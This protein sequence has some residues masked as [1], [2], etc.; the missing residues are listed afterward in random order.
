MV[1]LRAGAA[2]R[3]LRHFVIRRGPD[4]TTVGIN[5]LIG[6]TER[7]LRDGPQ[8]RRARLHLALGE[9][10]KALLGDRVVIQKV[11]VNMV[12]N[13]LRLWRLCHLLGGRMSLAVPARVTPWS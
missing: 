10:A 3:Q 4:R 13:V 11:A 2:I 8:V 7:L 6:E 5:E 12:R 9:Q 1:A